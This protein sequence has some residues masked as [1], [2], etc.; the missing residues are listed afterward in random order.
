MIMFFQHK[1]ILMHTSYF[2]CHGI[3]LF[4]IQALPDNVPLALHPGLA[5]S[6]LYFC[7]KGDVLREI[8]VKINGPRF[9]HRTPYQQD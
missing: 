5:I 1:A 7:F 6:S 9:V 4:V 8:K 3:C 2:S